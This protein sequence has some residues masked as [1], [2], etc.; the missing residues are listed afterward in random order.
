[1]IAFVSN[2]VFIIHKT[3]VEILFPVF[4][5]SLLQTINQL[6]EV[7]HQINHLVRIKWRGETWTPFMQEPITTINYDS[8][9]NILK[10]WNLWIDGRKKST[11]RKDPIAFEM[12][13]FVCC[14]QNAKKTFSVYLFHCFSS[15]HSVHNLTVVDLS[16]A[17]Y[18]RVHI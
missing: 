3:V 13:C 6:F 16:V 4:S 9:M 17:I 7:Q 14:N 1:M 10:R 2:I 12:V 11:K 15:L 18:E 5:T 8:S